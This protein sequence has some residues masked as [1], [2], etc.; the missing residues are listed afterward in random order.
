M[1]LKMMEVHR[2]LQTDHRKEEQVALR[3]G[4]CKMRTDHRK[5][6][7][8]EVPPSPRQELRKDL[9]KAWI[10]THFHQMNHWKGEQQK[11]VVESHMDRFLIA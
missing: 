5:L 1:D 9:Q 2:I 7:K 4:H 10:H 8:E 3:V 6:E 11:V